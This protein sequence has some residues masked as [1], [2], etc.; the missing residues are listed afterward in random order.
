MMDERKITNCLLVLIVLSGMVAAC[1]R[2][3]TRSLISN[4]LLLPSS[5]AGERV[6]NAEI[7]IALVKV[8]ADGS[9]AITRG[10]RANDRIDLS[11]LPK[12]REAAPKGRIWL[13]CNG[14][15]PLATV[16]SVIDQVAAYSGFDKIDFLVRSPDGSLASLPYDLI[17]PAPLIEPAYFDEAGNKLGSKIVRLEIR[18][19]RI[20]REKMVVPA[21]SFVTLIDSS[22][23]WQDGVNAIDFLTSKHISGYSFAKRPSLR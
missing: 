3:N 18:P 14:E 21:E 9:L 15:I 12:L 10:G 16:L 5:Q 20:D 4:D 8:A 17:I 1:H 2:P 6:A 19:G 11:S 7:P 23:S 22:G 13:A